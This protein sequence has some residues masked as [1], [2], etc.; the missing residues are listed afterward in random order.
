[1]ALLAVKLRPSFVF[2]TTVLNCLLRGGV[3][4]RIRT[5]TALFLSPSPYI[6]I[7][8]QLQLYIKEKKKE[9][10]LTTPA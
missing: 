10:V 5:F 4:G 9:E 1:M 7:T 6:D 2:W 8:I 3:G